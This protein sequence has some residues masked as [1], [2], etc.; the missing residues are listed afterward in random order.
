MTEPIAVKVVA[1]PAER[2]RQLG[3]APDTP[4]MD[5]WQAIAEAVIDIN[6]RIAVLETQADA[7]RARLAGI[8]YSC[9]GIEQPDR[10][11]TGDR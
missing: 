1:P 2:L 4:R 8:D 6:E 3:L 7:R 9:L 10:T 11:R 5:L